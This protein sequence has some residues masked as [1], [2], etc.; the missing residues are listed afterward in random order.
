MSAERRSGRDR[1]SGADRRGRVSRALARFNIFMHENWYRDVILI[2]LAVLWVVLAIDLSAT[3]KHVQAGR[4]FA[5]SVTCAVESAVG[6]A[7]REV[8]AGSA[9]PVGPPRFLRNLERL[10]YRPPPLAVREHAASAYVASIALAIERQ[11]GVRG[12]RLIRPDGSLNCPVLLVLAHTG[13]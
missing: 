2:A 1:R 11:V 13:R 5:I 10:G 12:R 3:N 4:R 6:E 9:A 7:G 8:I